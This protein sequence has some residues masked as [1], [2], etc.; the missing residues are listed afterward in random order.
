MTVYR[1]ITVA[2]ITRIAAVFSVIIVLIAEIIFTIFMFLKEGFMSA[3]FT[4]VM[5]VL[6]DFLFYIMLC[7]IALDSDYVFFRIK[8]RE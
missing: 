7:S 8:K 6:L 5:L 2:D 3:T 4:F 1:E